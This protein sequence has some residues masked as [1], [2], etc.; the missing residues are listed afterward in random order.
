MLSVPSATAV[1]GGSA[2]SGTAY[3]F[4]VKLS[5]ATGSCSGALIAPQWVLTSATCFPSVTSVTAPPQA[6]TAIVGRTQLDAID[7]HE[8][9][10]A[11]LVPQGDR[12]IVLARLA[13]K[14]DNVSVV[15][16]GDTAPQSGDS[17]QVVG[18]GRSATEWVPNQAHV[19][20]ATVDS[21]SATT[22]TVSSTSGPTTCKGDAGGP[23]VRT[24]DGEREL[25]AVNHASWQGGC[26]GETETRTGAVESRTDDLHDALTQQTTSPI[27]ARYLDLGGPSSF[28][29]NAIGS[30]FAA[31]GGTGQNYEHG[32]IYYSA[33][34]GA[35]IVQDQILAKYLAIG[36]PAA[37]GFPVTDQNTTPDGIGRYNHFG[38]TDPAG[39]ASIYWTPTTG[40]HEINGAIRGKWAALGWETGLGYPTTDETA[41]T[42]IDGSAGRYN[43]FSL[44]DTASIYWSTN[45]GAHEIRGDIRK[46]WLA[47]GGAPKLNFPSTD[48]SITPDGIGRYNH[49][50]HPDGASV[51]WTPSTGAHEIQG[52]IR[53]KWAAM[54]W[55][56]GP[57]Y[58]TTDESITPDTIGRYNH[59]TNSTSIYWSPSSGV[60]SVAGTIRDRWASLGWEAGRLGYP[61]SDEYSITGGRRS[62]FQHGYITW[63]STNNTTQVFY[64]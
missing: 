56:T 31:A 14:V 51:Y 16:L 55:E 43:D 3:P 15:P 36:G 37:I 12:P 58:P 7:G 9:A 61:T 8:V 47:L 17:V 52:A 30:E 27:L 11:W 60:H 41:V 57:G 1:T 59:F 25:V 42:G 63:A 49:F 29:G 24:E 26:L 40:A 28:L 19:A 45:S 18:Y 6:T 21:T 32:A 4:V 53:T 33:A 48:E 38:F 46:K 10:V 34:T 62:D 2:V 54:G 20:T 39:D 13:S 22:F 23:A 64:Y 35:H 50:N 44:A 5:N